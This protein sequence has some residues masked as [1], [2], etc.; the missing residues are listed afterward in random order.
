MAKK[1]STKKKTTKK[2]PKKTSKLE[3][4]A[5]GP[6]TLED[7]EKRLIRIEKLMLLSLDESY[8]HERERA[9]VA[10]IERLVKSGDLDK[11]SDFDVS[12]DV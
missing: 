3:I 9:R 8:L 4:K 6:V 7:L 12:L 1:K 11:L 2:A 10:E 5:R